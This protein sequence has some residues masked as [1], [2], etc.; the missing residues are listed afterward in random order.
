M[1][2]QKGNIVKHF[3]GKDLIEKNIYQIVAVNPVYTGTKTFPQDAVVIY[4]SLFQNEKAFVREYEDLVQE[5][6]DEQKELY[7]QNYRIEPL[8]EEELE[9]LNNPEFIQAKKAFIEEQNNNKTL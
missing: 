2:L 7:H 8:T 4:E 3:K 9:L 5:L 6:S 1:E